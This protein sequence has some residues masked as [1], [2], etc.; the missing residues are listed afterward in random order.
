MKKTTDAVKILHKRY[1]GD[2]QD[3]IKSLEKERSKKDVECNKC[4]NFF[5]SGAKI[6]N[7][8]CPKCKSNESLSISE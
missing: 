5:T 2:D 4:G 1:V 6:E 8:R 7:I 3:R